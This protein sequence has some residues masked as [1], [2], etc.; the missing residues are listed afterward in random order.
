MDHQNQQE[1]SVM[2]P[3]AQ[4]ETHITMVKDGSSE[5]LTS[6]IIVINDIH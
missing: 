2:L 6:D 1:A 5:L 3:R 4:G